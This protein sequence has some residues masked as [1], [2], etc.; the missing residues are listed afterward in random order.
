MNRQVLTDAELKAKFEEVFP[1]YAQR[2][3][4]AIANGS[5][6]EV[7][8]E[9]VREAQ[10]AMVA[11]CA[12]MNEDDASGIPAI[13]I[14]ETYKAMVEAEN[15]DI[16]YYITYFL[17]T[18]QL[19]KPYLDNDDLEMV[20]KYFI[21]GE[22]FTLTSFGIS[23][24]LNALAKGVTTF[25]ACASTLVSTAGGVA[26]IV[27]FV[28]VTALIPIIYFMEKP[29]VTI[30][31]FINDLKHDIWMVD[32][33]CKHGKILSKIKEI[34]SGAKVDS[35]LAGVY[36]SSKRDDALV[37]S[38][39]AYKFQVRKSGK[40]AKDFYIGLECPLSSLYGGN[41]CYASF[42]ADNLSSVCDAVHDKQEKTYHIEE[43]GYAIDIRCNSKSGSVAY[44]I[45]RIY[46]A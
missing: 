21:L 35:H 44:Y 17:N 19:V 4:T 33:H 46:E 27:T 1:E 2:L 32:S 28:V 23:V 13:I 20:A 37:G 18:L 40:A 3:N 15:G 34:K 16:K 9:I 42:K 12:G 41:C 38:T 45:G 6:E 30:M 14:D 7:Y 25:E 36:T 10:D 22:I 29:A 26:S 5:L 39:V 8:N 11:A 24:Y 31:M 43:D